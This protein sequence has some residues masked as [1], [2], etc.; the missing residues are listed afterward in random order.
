M[1]SIAA[2]TEIRLNELRLAVCGLRKRTVPR[3]FSKRHHGHPG[4]FC[5][6]WCVGFA[7]Q[8]IMPLSIFSRIGTHSAAVGLTGDLS[9]GDPNARRKAF[10]TSKGMSANSGTWGGG[11]IC[12][13][14]D[15]GEYANRPS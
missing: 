2:S 6:K 5:E 15:C 4:A 10:A 14:D 9:F 11:V 1:R 12:V 13:S 7:L 8:A 3:P